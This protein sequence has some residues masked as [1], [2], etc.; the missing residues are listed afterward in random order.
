MRLLDVEYTGKKL[1]LFFEYMEYDLKK[2]MYSFENINQKMNET[3]IKTLLRQLLSGLAYCHSK[4]VL[5]RDL[6]PQNILIS[7]QTELKIADFGLA[8]LFSIPNRPYTKEVRTIVNRN[9]MVSSA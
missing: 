6:K 7:D 2:I 9:A 3:T 8:R 5:H 4:R 1:L